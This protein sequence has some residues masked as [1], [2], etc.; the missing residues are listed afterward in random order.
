MKSIS[1]R[2]ISSPAA[3]MSRSS[4]IRSTVVRRFIVDESAFTQD[5]ALAVETN[6]AVGQVLAQ[7]Q[8][9]RLRK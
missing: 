8:R 1:S 9:L 3:T 2:R 7:V 4:S 5:V 6:R